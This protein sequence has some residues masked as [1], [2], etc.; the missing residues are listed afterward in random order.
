MKIQRK[1][2]STLK[3]LL[4]DA[5]ACSPGDRD[6]LIRTGMGIEE[7]FTAAPN[8]LPALGEVL[9]GSLEAL[10][11]IFQSPPGSLPTAWQAILDGLKAAADLGAA[12][13]DVLFSH[14]EFKKVSMRYFRES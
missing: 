8:A 7:A 2:I 10:Q 11:A 14:K 3:G 13:H 6:A 5:S 1:F 9:A 12:A 4:G